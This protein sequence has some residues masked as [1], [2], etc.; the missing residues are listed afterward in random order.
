M[1]LTVP[2][3]GK[4][5]SLLGSL[6][7]KFRQVIHKHPPTKATIINK[8]HD[9]ISD[10]SMPAFTTTMQTIT[11]VSPPLNGTNNI[12]R[13][14][15]A[16][17]LCLSS[18]TNA[19][20]SLEEQ[21]GLPPKPKK[22]LTPYFRFMAEHRAKLRAENPKVPAIELVRMI[23]KKWEACD[24]SIKTRLQEQ[25]N[26]DRQKYIE[27]RTKYESNISDKQRKD[28]RELKPE[29]KETKEKRIM[30]KRVKELGRPKK[31][32]SAFI[33][34]LSKEKMKSPPLPQQPWRDWFK[35]T[36]IK[37][38]Q[39]SQDE[40]NVH[41]QESRLEIEVYRK[42]LTSW[43]E[44]MIRLGNVD[45]IRHGSLIDP[46]EPKPKSQNKLKK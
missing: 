20:K 28:I 13:P 43:E 39:L 31:P 24:P 14:I 34:F 15:T 21:V 7:S 45:V 35:Q 26:I 12:Y 44:K 41:L 19:T 1:I 22:P 25:Y 29:I 10:P 36:K 40:K 27:N 8:M 5:T 46:P 37:W 3:L 11:N 32:A 2:L 6:V 30:R 9:N 17:N 42:E 4:T 16:A 33:K 38:A 23:S 18:K